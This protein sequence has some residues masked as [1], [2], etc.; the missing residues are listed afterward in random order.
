MTALVALLLL[1]CSRCPADDEWFT[2]EDELSAAQVLNI[3]ELYHLDSPSDASC[4]QICETTYEVYRGWFA[5]DIKTCDWAFSQQ[6]YDD[7]LGLDSGGGTDFDAPVGN[8]V[9]QGLGVSAACAL[10]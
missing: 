4:E 7:A 10:E 2:M 3:V 9:C 8:I 1:S 5:A 6:A